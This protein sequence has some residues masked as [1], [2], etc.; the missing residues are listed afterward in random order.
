MSLIDRLIESG[1]LK[2]PLLVEAFKKLARENFLPEEVKNQAPINA[3]LP[4]G[5]NQTN[6][7]PLVVAFMLERLKLMAGQRVLDIG[8]GSGWTTALIAE[9]VGRNGKVIAVEIVDELCHFGAQNVERLGY[10]NVEFR[11]GDWYR[12]ISENE[13]FDRI[14]AACAFP[15]VP[16]QLKQALSPLGRM[17]IPVDSDKWGNQSI[18][19]IWKTGEA[20]FEEKNYPGFVFVPMTS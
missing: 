6:S 13:R 10:G 4:I 17:V 12:L 15:S 3:A 7:Q 19:E 9:M 18:R 16:A 14:H 2:N 8:S 11:C 1:Y 20:V 5:F